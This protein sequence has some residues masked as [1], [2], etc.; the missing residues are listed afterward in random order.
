MKVM[1]FSGA[2]VSAE[3]G[4]ST[5]RDKNGIWSRFNHEEVCN[6]AVWQQ[7]YGGVHAFYNRLRRAVAEAEPNDFH[8]AVARWSKLY[9][10]RNVTQ[11]VDDLFERAGVEQTL[12]VHGFINDLKCIDCNFAWSQTTDWDSALPCPRCGHARCIKPGIIMFGETAPAYLDLF[13]ELDYVSDQRGEKPDGGVIIVAGTDEQ[14]VDIS[15]MI[16]E[17]AYAT[18]NVLVNPKPSGF[19]RG[20]AIYDVAIQKPAGEAVAMLDQLLAEQAAL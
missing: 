4:L 6:F 10:V 11:N 19:A 13:V 8:R 2:G 12:H 1:I 9:D 15:I 7:N 16:Q 14:V 17:H 3:S 18:H 20:H 5:F